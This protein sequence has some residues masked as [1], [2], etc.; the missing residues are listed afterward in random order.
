[1]KQDTSIQ[2]NQGA[3]DPAASARMVVS[4]DAE[5]VGTRSMFLDAIR[6]MT[7]NRMAVVGLILLLV[8]S[9]ASVL[10]PWLA[11]HDPNEQNWFARLQGPSWEYP[12]GTDDF[13]RCVFSRV[14]YG[15]RLSLLS[16]LLPVLLGATVGTGLGI[17]AG[18]RGGYYDS[19][20]MR[21]MDVLL[22]LPSIFLALAI[23]GTL[24]PGW[25]N[26]V[27]AVSIV[28]V[29]AYARIVRGRVLVLR[30]ME[31]IESARA[32]GA[33]HLR[34]IL[35]YI[36]PNIMSPIIVQSTLSIGFAI[37]SMAGLSFLGLGVQPPTSDW[38]EMLSSG[39]R[40]LPEGYWLEVFPGL[41]IML[42]VLGA[43]LLGDGLRDALDPRLKK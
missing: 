6:R 4:G 3:G 15:G 25:L 29:P 43:N 7:R 18:Y 8:V 21:A 12:F 16:G 32:V 38:G 19:V 27:L 42:V 31:F 1:M 41:F 13:G 36:L 30:E 39:R 33:K 5:N 20:I 22:S 14:L 11:P 24:G 37:L 17:I 2:N 34:I 28:S 35:K 10:A 9:A 26:A 40:F 23:V